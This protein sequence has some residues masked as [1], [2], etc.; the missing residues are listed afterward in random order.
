MWGALNRLAIIV[1]LVTAAAAAVFYVVRGEQR[2]A[3]LEAELEE[4]RSKAAET[5]ASNA[6]NSEACKQ[7]AQQLSYDRYLEDIEGREELEG[8]M[9]ELGCFPAAKVEN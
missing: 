1:T 6:A 8:R 4:A 3:R 7:L 2:N 5:A 9:V